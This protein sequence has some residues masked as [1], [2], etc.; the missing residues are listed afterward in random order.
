MSSIPSSHAS[1]APGR[2][3]L[4]GPTGSGK[5]RAAL[6]LA[7]VLEQALKLP[8]SVINA[9]SRQIYADFPIITAQP[10]PEERAVCPHLLYGY[11]PTTQ[12]SSAGQWADKARE[13]IAT[14][15][16][17]GRLPILVGGTGL[18]LKALLDGMVDIPAPDPGVVAR[19]EAEYRAGGS[20]PMHAR[21]GGVDPEYAARIHP[22]DRQRILRALEVWES[23][24]QTFTWWHSRTPMA[25]HAPPVLR[26]GIGLPLDELTPLLERRIHAMLAGGALEEAAAA[27]RSC[28]DL[29]AP[30]W[31]GIGCA[32]LGAHL[33]GQISRDECLKRWI[34]NTRAYAKRQWTWFRADKRIHWLRP[35]EDAELID[36]ASSWLKSC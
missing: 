30:G 18:Y 16:R 3:C 22:N 24:G 33:A 32:E 15:E 26:L 11:L 8:V 7:R 9:D 6:V 19:L 1:R 21:L 31:S 10:T 35:L 25:E 5:S 2:I 36:A 14:V 29:G 23:T 34:R 27:L 28:P 12:K 4:V 13:A 20:A 17:Q